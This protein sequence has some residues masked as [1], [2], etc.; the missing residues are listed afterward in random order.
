[1]KKRITKK[2]LEKGI[3]EGKIRE[4]GILQENII[5]YDKPY[6]VDKEGKILEYAGCGCGGSMYFCN[7]CKKLLV[8]ENDFHNSKKMLIVG[9]DGI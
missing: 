9:V 5:G 2:E 8:H 4:M 1:M 3:K 7:F 6:Y